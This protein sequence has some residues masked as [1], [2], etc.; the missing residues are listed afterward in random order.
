[1]ADPPVSAASVSTPTV[2]FTRSRKIRLAIGKQRGRL[3][4]QRPGKC[5]ITRDALHHRRLDN[6]GSAPCQ[7]PL[8][9]RPRPSGLARFA[10]RP[11]RLRPLESP[12]LTFLRATV[13][14]NDQRTAS[15]CEPDPAARALIERVPGDG[16]NPFYV[17]RV[18]QHEPQRRAAATFVQAAPD[19]RL[20][21][22]ILYGLEPIARIYSTQWRRHCRRGNI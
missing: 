4:E 2:A 16:A 20:L 10:F 11:R 22:Q 17:R 8:A 1:L 9:F 7:S 3:V 19:M 12:L 21:N 13:Q 6:L 15:L 14:Q 5:R 18:G